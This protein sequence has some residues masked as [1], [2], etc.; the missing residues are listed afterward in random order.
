MDRFDEYFFITPG[1][2]FQED[3][4]EL[5]TAVNLSVER[6]RERW[7]TQKGQSILIRWETNHFKRDVL[8]E[9]VG[10]YYNHTDIRGINLSNKI[11]TNVDLSEIDLFSANLVDTTFERCN[12]TNTWL[13]HANLSRT[14]FKW[15]KMNDVILDGVSFNNRTKF[16]G[17]NLSSIDFTL[18]SLLQDLA[19]GQQKIEHLERRSRYF[20]TFLK[21]TCDYGRSFRRFVICCMG[22]IFVF[23]LMYSLIPDMVNSSD[24]LGCLYFSALTFM[25]IG[26]TDI[27][28][29]SSIGK[30]ITITEVSIGYI[31]LGLLV[32]IFSTHVD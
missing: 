1:V 18:A 15:T 25:R 19:L 5:T 7:N 27:H 28:P 12:L 8:N 24:F 14:I 10:K 11:L 22:V 32:A 30:L 3:N 6:L 29:I 26:Y 2:D 23:S 4:S 13:S 31:M 21:W 9:S 20:A 17:V 16:L